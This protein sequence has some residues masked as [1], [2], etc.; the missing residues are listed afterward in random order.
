[1]TGWIVALCFAIT[2]FMEFIPLCARTYYNIRKTTLEAALAEKYPEELGWE[3]LEGWETNIGMKIGW[4]RVLI[5]ANTYMFATRLLFQGFQAPLTVIDLSG[6]CAKSDVSFIDTEKMLFVFMFM[7][8]CCCCGFLAT[9]AS[10]VL[11]MM[12]YEMPEDAEEGEE[13]EMN[14]LSGTV[15][16]GGCGCGCGFFVSFLIAILFFFVVQIPDFFGGEIE[17]PIVTVSFLYYLL[18]FGG[19]ALSLK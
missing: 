16:A 18:L 5:N 12:G 14:L 6:P 11:K 19:A 4:K 10:A 8:A 17:E 2:T 15:A 13:Q 7:M 3:A 1:M 9:A